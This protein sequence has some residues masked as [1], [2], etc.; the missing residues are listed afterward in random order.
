M[1]AKSIWKNDE[2]YI[3]NLNK[4][5]TFKR[6]YLGGEKRPLGELKLITAM[7]EIEETENSSSNWCE[8]FNNAIAILKKYAFERVDK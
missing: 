5:N 6:L 8:F 3:I 1:E 2:L 7:K 4:E